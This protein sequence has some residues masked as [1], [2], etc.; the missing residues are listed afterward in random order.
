MTIR[1]AKTGKPSENIYVIHK[2]DGKS[3]MGLMWSELERG[4]FEE[5]KESFNSKKYEACKKYNEVE[6][7]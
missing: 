1:L 3:T 6:N 5:M 7:Q 2:L 4:T